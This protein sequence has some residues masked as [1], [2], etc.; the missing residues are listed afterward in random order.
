MGEEEVDFGRFYE[1][2]DLNGIVFGYE[3]I[4]APFV[5]N[6]I[7]Y[8]KGWRQ[9]HVYYRT[10]QKCSRDFFNYLV[11]QKILEYNPAKTSTCRRFPRNTP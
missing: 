10:W 6:F 5:Q 1:L 4:D 11:K 2:E 3:Q 7:D 9:V 8:R